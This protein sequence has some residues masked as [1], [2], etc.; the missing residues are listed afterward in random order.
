MVRATKLFCG[1]TII[2]APTEGAN[3]GWEKRRDRPVRTTD[4]VRARQVASKRTSEL[5]T[6]RELRLGSDAKYRTKCC[7]IESGVM[8]NHERRWLGHLQRRPLLG[9]QK[10]RLR[11]LTTR[12]DG[13]MPHSTPVDAHMA[14]NPGATDGSRSKTI[15]GEVLSAIFQSPRFAKNRTGANIFADRNPRSPVVPA[16]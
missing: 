10:A 14:S 5:V 12:P 1:I 15:R 6:V 9:A 4:G 13:R 2:I 8:A 16:S 7:T 11:A 3:G